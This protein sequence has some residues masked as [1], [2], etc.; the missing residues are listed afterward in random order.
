MVKLRKISDESDKD[1]GKLIE[2]YKEAFPLEE[3]RN[4]EQL[5]SM[6]KDEPRMTFNAIECD[7][8]LCGLFVYWDFKTFY[9]LEHLAVFSDMRNKKIGE[10]TLA[11]IAENLKGLRILEAEPADTEIA[12]RRVHYYE[13]NGY[14]VYNKDYM[15]PSY[16]PE[17]D[18]CALWVMCNQADEELNEKLKLLKDV[19]YY[20]FC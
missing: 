20:R 19:V 8:E 4:E 13:R 15:Q 2:L 18:G 14:K 12:V 7:G 17:G 3:R 16:R 5:I 6:L 1:F 9:Y 11:W 10:Q